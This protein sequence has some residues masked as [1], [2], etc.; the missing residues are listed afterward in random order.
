MK[1]RDIIAHLAIKHGNE[2]KKIYQAI[3]QKELVTEE[4]VGNSLSSL[5]GDFIVIIDEDYPNEFKSIP[6]PPF[7]IFLSEADRK[8]IG[9]DSDMHFKG[10]EMVKNFTELPQEDEV[11]EE[12]ELE[13]EETDTKKL[14]A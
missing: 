12:D 8:R 14:D 5:E 10:Y 4:E 1:G 11:W 6:F 7:V 2:W 3:Q 13:D 9:G